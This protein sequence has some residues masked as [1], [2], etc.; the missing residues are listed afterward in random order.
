MRAYNNLPDAEKAKIL[1]AMKNSENLSKINHMVNKVMFDDGTSYMVDMTNYDSY[2][3]ICNMQEIYT[4]KSDFKNFM[5]ARVNNYFNGKAN[6]AFMSNVDNFN[7]LLN[8]N[9]KLLTD[10]AETR[11]AAQ[12]C[13]NMSFEEIEQ[14]RVKV[15]DELPYIKTLLQIDELKKETEKEMGASFTK[16]ALAGLYKLK[17]LFSSQDT[18]LLPPG[19][20][21]IITTDIQTV[22]HDMEIAQGGEE[23]IEYS[24]EA[25]REE[26]LQFK[27]HNLVTTREEDEQRTTATGN[28]YIENDFRRMISNNGEYRKTIEDYMKTYSSREKQNSQVYRKEDEMERE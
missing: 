8:Y 13:Q 3:S 16:K 12:G 26:E 14:A 22:Q 7:G 11:D 1:S 6:N 17:N 20:D 9:G 24:N 23:V 18:N 10:V 27:D 15:M 5:S 2:K 4:D 28:N 25:K 21:N 19:A